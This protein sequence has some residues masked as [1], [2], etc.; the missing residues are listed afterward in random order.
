V[1][2]AYAVLKKPPDKDFQAKISN[3]RFAITR[4]ALCGGWE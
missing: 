2:D 1:P 3:D 4:L